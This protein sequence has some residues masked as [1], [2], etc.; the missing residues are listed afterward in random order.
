MADTIDPPIVLCRRHLWGKGVKREVKVDTH[1][2][3]GGGA[4]QDEKAHFKKD[5]ART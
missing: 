1:I 4:Q 3:L 5:E 2:D